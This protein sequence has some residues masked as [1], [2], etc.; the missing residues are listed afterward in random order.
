M[1]AVIVS[2]PAFWG[3]LNSDW[4]MCTKGKNQSPIDIEPNILLFDPSLKHIIINGDSVSIKYWY[5]Y[6]VLHVHNCKNK[7]LICSFIDFSKAFGSVLRIGL[8][9]KTIS[10]KYQLKTF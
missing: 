10:Q 1:V 9:K 3:R 7:K 2:G 6:F 5:I 4:F 8:W